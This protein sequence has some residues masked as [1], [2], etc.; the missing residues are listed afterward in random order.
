MQVAL[1][2][3]EAPVTDSLPYEWY[4]SPNVHFLTMLDFRELTH[5]GNFRI[6]KRV[7]D[8]W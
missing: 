7:A 5:H 4:E 3:R 2:G 6:V 1:R 8:Y